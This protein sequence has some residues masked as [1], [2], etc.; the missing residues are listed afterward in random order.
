MFD[1]DNYSIELQFYIE[2]SK[3]AVTKGGSSVTDITEKPTTR[4]YP[5]AKRIVG[6]LW[7][8]SVDY[9]EATWE[10]NPTLKI[11]EVEAVVTEFSKMS[12]STQEKQ[13]SLGYD[14]VNS[15]G[16]LPDY[17]VS[18]YDLDGIDD[19][20]GTGTTEPVLK[21]RTAFAKCECGSDTVNSPFHS[22][23][24]PKVKP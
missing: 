23:W 4:N 6:K 16:D 1:Q 2:T 11:F 24:C 14:Y 20:Y 5:G 3:I 15:V 9:H 12:S 10:Y 13:T 8:N 19:L 17:H 7:I 22:D 18:Q 21:P